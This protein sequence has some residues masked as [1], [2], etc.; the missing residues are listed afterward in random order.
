MDTVM[1]MGMDMDMGMGINNKG[2]NLSTWAYHG[3]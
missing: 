3:A 2:S 1:D